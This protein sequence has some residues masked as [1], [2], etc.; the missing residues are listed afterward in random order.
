[1]TEQTLVIP[2]KFDLVKSR[3]ETQDGEAVTVLFG[4]MD[5]MI[6]GGVLNNTAQW[7]EDATSI[8]QRSFIDHDSAVAWVKQKCREY[9]GR[10]DVDFAE[11][12]G[13]RKIVIPRGPTPR[14]RM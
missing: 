6:V 7:G 2:P 5:G 12:S 1:M 8:I 9:C 13:E 3:Q 14:V 10:E 11:R 4:R